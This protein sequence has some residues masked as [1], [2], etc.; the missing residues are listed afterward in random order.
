MRLNEF[1]IGA[2]LSQSLDRLK[3]MS[4]SCAA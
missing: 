4:V 3:A 2:S 1:P